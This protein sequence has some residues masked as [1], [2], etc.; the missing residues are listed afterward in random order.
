MNT[1]QKVTW[2]TGF[3]HFITH[4]YMTLLPAVLV[5]II[6]EHSMSFLDLGIIAN[7]GYF[8]YGLGAFPA[9]H[10]ADKY[11]SKR[12]LTI[13]VLGMAV[14]SILVGLSVGTAGFAGTYALLGIF[15]S[16]HHPAG[17]SLIARRIEKKGKA[18]GLHGVMGNVG[19]FFSPL[20]AGLCVLFFNTWRAA[21]LIYGVLGLVFFLIMY[22]AEIEH[23][24]NLSWHLGFLDRE[25]GEGKH[26][27]LPQEVPLS[28][29]PPP[30]T[31]P[32]P[33]CRLAY[34]AHG[35]AGTSTIK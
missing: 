21:Y 22:F 27:Q 13:G 17:L 29:E 14:S 31:I 9:G 28:P 23:E 32:Q 16:I 10:L 4:G 18:L 24:S 1:E 26:V 30:A 7:I 5:V 15:A 8:L 6:S 19:L 11:G 34:S 20:F 35:L 12:I 25:K 2:L 33:S 3:S